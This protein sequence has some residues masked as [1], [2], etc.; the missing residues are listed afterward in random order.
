MGKEKANSP[1]RGHQ[2]YLDSQK[3]FRILKTLLYVLIGVAIF[4]LGLCLN[5][6]EKS[7]IFTVIAILMVLPAAKALVSVIVLL[8]YRSVDAEAVEEVRGLLSGEDIMYTDMV[9][10]S[11]DKVMFFSFLVIA[12]DEILCLVGREKED[13]AYIEKYLKDELKKRMLLRKLYITKDRKNFLEK[14]AHAE[15]A[16]DIPDELTAYLNSLMV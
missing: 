8:P 13:I 15:P 14:V 9:F 12:Q 7:N 3:R 6:F 2:G 5:K 16:T 11:R 1:A 4:V 10:T